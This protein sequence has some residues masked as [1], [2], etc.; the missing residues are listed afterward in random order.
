META[1]KQIGGSLVAVIPAEYVKEIG[2]SRGQVVNVTA[3]GR[4]L[5]LEPVG[6]TTKRRRRTY[7]ELLALCD[8]NAPPD[9]FES[10]WANMPSVGKEIIE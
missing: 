10:E 3:K 7:A 9:P 8:L 5:I 1:L 4:K 2:L 6:A